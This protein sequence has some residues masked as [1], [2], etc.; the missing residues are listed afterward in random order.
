MTQPYESLSPIQVEQKLRQVVTDLTLAEKAL[1]E[2][3]DEETTAEITFRAAHRAAMLS[4]QCPRVARGGCTTAERDAWV[5]DQ[6]AGQWQAYRIAQA[7]REAAQDHIRTVRDIAT[8]VQS[9]GA[10]V[11]T[12]YSMAGTT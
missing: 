10:L 9:I 1:R 7:R 12:A 11:R 6:C 3:R 4:P 8:A 5:E 2:A